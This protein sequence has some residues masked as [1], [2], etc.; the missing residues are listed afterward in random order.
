[1]KS[2]E[3]LLMQMCVLDSHHLYCPRWCTFQT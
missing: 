1:M 3:Q 2:S